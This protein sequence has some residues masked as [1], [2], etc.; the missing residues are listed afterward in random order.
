MCVAGRN[1]E[2]AQTNIESWKDNNLKIFKYDVL[3]AIIFDYE[4]D[5]VIHAA[6]NAH[7]LAFNS[8]PVGTIIGNI[9]G[10]IIYLSILRRMVERDFY[11]F[12]L[13]KCMEMEIYLL[14]NLKRSI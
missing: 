8:D 2:K 6:G 7:P 3:K 1:L 12:H 4:V 5:Y 11:L 10:T 9:E 13:G 14:M